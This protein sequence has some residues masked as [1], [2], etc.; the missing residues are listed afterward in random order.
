[1]KIIW[2]ELR[3]LLLAFPALALLIIPTAT[4]ASLG[5]SIQATIFMEGA[6]S[7]I[8]RNPSRS[9]SATNAC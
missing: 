5:N 1:M 6:A 4:G 7:A 9:T 2:T 8:A 3:L